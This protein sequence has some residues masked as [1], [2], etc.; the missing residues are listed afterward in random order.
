MYEE[1]KINEKPLPAFDLNTPIEKDQIF[2]FVDRSTLLNNSLVVEITGVEMG[3]Y[4]KLILVY[5]YDNNHY[6]LDL[7]KTNK[8]FMIDKFGRIPKD[9]VGKTVTLSGEAFEG[10]IKDRDVTGVKI[11]VS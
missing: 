4:G 6:G 8:A 11:T 5:L 3:Q 1:E 10:K 2:Q 9:W 7:N